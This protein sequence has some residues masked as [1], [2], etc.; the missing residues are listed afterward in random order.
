MDTAESVELMT[1]LRRRLVDEN[2]V[3]LSVIALDSALLTVRESFERR[4]QRLSLELSGLLDH[5]KLSIANDGLSIKVQLEY[6]ETNIAATLRCVY[7]L[8]RIQ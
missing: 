5:E 6:L 4:I 3:G 7:V 8:R 1:Q 2:A